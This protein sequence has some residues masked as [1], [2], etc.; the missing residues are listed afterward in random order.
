MLISAI[1]KAFERTH[2]AFERTHLLTVLRAYTLM[3]LWACEQADDTL[4]ARGPD[5]G[6]D[7]DVLRLL[8]L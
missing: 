7:S 8:S 4:A 6:K 1:K 5:A 2:K 3:R